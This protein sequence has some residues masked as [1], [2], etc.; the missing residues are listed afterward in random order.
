[1][2]KAG[3]ATVR[4]NKLLDGQLSIGEWLEQIQSQ[5]RREEQINRLVEENANLAYFFVN[6]FC[7]NLDF[8]HLLG[9]L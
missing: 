6:N 9:S 1:M 4:R 7:R 3:V 5:A 8:L 2:G